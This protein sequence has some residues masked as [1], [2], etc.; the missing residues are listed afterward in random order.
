VCPRILCAVGILTTFNFTL[1]VLT[2]DRSVLSGQSLHCMH[3]FYFTYRYF[4]LVIVLAC[5]CT[6]DILVKMSQKAKRT[7]R[8]RKEAVQE[9][10]STSDP[11]SAILQELRELRKRVD[12]LSSAPQ[13]STTIAPAALPSTSVESAQSAVNAIVQQLPASPQALL[14]H[15]DP[16]PAAQLP[17]TSLIPLNLKKDIVSGKDVNLATLLIPL[18]ERR[19]IQC[20][21]REIRVGDDTIA[22]KPQKDNRLLKNLNCADFIQAFTVYKDIMC[23]A[24]PGR[25]AE[26][27]KYMSNVVKMAGD[28]PGF[29]FY[30]YHLEFSARAAEL[31]VRGYRVDWAKMDPLLFQK[32]TA[33]KL[34]NSCKLCSAF[35]H[36]SG[37]CPLAAAGSMVSTSKPFSSGK[38]ICFRHNSGTCERGTSCQY[39]HACATCKSPQHTQRECK[40]TTSGPRKHASTASVQSA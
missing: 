34:A 24:Y 28:W 31:L 13:L 27:D 29:V 6:R 26:L 7:S 36:H 37:F 38:K 20:G 16:V 4:T 33:G 1:R 39:L 15:A 40:Q 35:D 18:R 11:M 21:Q 12:E 30:Q 19:F 8:K 5:L 23:E 10:V 2:V 17:E 3:V 14:S 22:L 32:V 9:S 25:R